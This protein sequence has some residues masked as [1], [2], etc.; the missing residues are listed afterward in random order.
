METLDISKTESMISNEIFQRLQ[1]I[2]LVDPYDAYQL[3]D[4]E[5][6]KIAIDLEM[7]QTEGTESIKK[8]DPNLVLKKKGGK[9]EG[10]KRDGQVMFCRSH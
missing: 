9:E 6:S 8:V 1:N 7:I 10:F 2:P 3:L 5:W 4:D